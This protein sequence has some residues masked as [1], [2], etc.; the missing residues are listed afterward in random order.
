MVDADTRGILSTRAGVTHGLTR[1]TDEVTGLVLATIIVNS[2]LH[3]DTGHQ[4][5]AL[6]SSAA[7]TLGRVK[8]D[9]RQRISNVQCYLP[10]KTYFNNTLCTATTRPLRVEAWVETVL[11]DASLVDRTIIVSATLWAVTLSVWVSSVSLGTRADRMV[12][13]CLTRGLGSTRVADNTRVNTPLVDA[14]FGLWTLGI[15]STLGSGCNY[16]Y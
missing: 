11:I 6:Q 15:L 5:I 2:A 14:C 13:A 9:N 4:R 10:V 12:G 8:L 3:I 16:K 1:L 7:H